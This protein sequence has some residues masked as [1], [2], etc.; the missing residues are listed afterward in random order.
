M[1]IIDIFK[2]FSS[3]FTIIQVAK[4]RKY[5]ILPGV[6]GIILFVLFWMVGGVIG[7]SFTTFLENFF[8]IQK[9]H[10]IIY[11]L[12]KILVWLTVV[13][14]YFLV[15]KSL[16]LVIIS[17]M[18]AVASARVEEVLTGKTYDFSFKE[19]MK[20]IWR[21]IDIGC[22][23]FFKQLVGTILV[24]L[25]GFVF[26]INLF[27]PILLFIMQ[28]YFTGFA[29]MDYTLERFELTPS[30]SMIF[31]KKKRFVAG[32]SGMIFTLLFLIPFVGIFI[33]P[34]VSTVAITQITLKLLEKK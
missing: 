11:V 30:E 20:F 12:I 16:L 19:N 31:L 9:Y 6:V 10:T 4:L 28:G 7:S 5:Y 21:G 27:I 34:I 29:F 32:V 24:F 3:S 26:P 13:I 33:A 1:N 15:Y 14:V 18:L 8:R 22:R 2:A 23:S 25:L 17:P